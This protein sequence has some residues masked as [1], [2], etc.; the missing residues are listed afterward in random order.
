MILHPIVSCFERYQQP[1]SPSFHVNFRSESYHI[2]PP[3]THNVQKCE[4][5]Q[6]GKKTIHGKLIK[7]MM[8]I[9]TNSGYTLLSEKP[10]NESV[11]NHNC[12]YGL[13]KPIQ[14]QWHFNALRTH[15]WLQKHCAKHG[16]VYVF[17]PCWANHVNSLSLKSP[18]QSY[19]HIL[20][21]L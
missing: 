3:S 19:S 2:V 16:S 12:V 21:L 9:Q 10:K 11:V 5:K 15:P 13:G 4:K 7:I 20:E 6:T 1:V 8:M 14:L 17:F 18:K